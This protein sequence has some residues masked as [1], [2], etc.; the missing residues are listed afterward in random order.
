MGMGVITNV[1]S[2]SAA[3]FLRRTDESMTRSLE[4]LSSGLRITRAADDAAGAAI[5]EGLRAQVGGVRQALRNTQ[6]GISV[7]RTADGALEATTSLLQRMRDLAVQAA[8]DGALDETSKAAVQ[9]EVAQLKEEL[10]RIAATTSFGGRRLLDGS[11]R[12]T[13]QVGANV[14]ETVTVVIGA[15]GAGLGVE[16][17]GL[18]EVDVTRTSSLAVTATRAVSDDEGVPTRGELRFAGDYVTPGVY[19]ASFE[20]LTGTIAYDGRTFDLDSVD[21]TGAVT[22]TDYL[23]RLTTA[24]LPVLGTPHTPF[25]GTA[26]GLHFDGETPGAASTVADAE[27]LSP[28]YRGRSGA[29][30]AI[31]L[32]DRA[33]ADVSSLRAYLG[34]VENRFHHILAGLDVMAENMT[35][36]M[37]RIRDAD[38]AQ[39]MVTLSRHQ[40]VAQAGTAM[41][42]QAN[43][44]PRSLLS[45]LG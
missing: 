39:E 2:L 36:S 44:A 41:L 37:S 14:G 8:N 5:T 28:S 11:Y 40:I 17:L 6:D 9:T 20:A 12:G 13:F 7:V 42:S 26:L 30:A 35:T 3:R 10:S 34:A 27:L 24:A 22:A 29:S 45:L 19:Q 33:V 1:P 18:Q 15:P 32:V 38:I 23:T 16:G 31:A 25:V 21:Y 43:S 4:R